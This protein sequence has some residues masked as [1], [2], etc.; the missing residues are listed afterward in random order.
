MIVHRTDRKA[1][2][3]TMAQRYAMAHEGER[4]LPVARRALERFAAVAERAHA[5][6]TAKAHRRACVEA[7][8][9][10]W[11]RAQR[12]KGWAQWPPQ[13]TGI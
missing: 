10:A 7:R 9:I 6:A 11:S 2:P 5:F 4:F 13:T 8:F 1:A 3:A 12:G